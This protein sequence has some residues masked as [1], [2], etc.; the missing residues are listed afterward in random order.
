MT[1]T[2]RIPYN[3]REPIEVL[4]AAKHLQGHTSVGQLGVYRLEQMGEGAIGDLTHHRIPRMIKAERFRISHLE[5]AARKIEDEGCAFARV[6]VLDR[7]STRDDCS[8]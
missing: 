6:T 2:G 4:T 3:A 1:E 7:Q 5:T 8:G